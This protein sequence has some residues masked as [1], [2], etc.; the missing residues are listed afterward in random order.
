[1]PLAMA[2]SYDEAISVGFYLHAVKGKPLMERFP[3]RGRC[4]DRRDFISVGLGVRL[5][6]L[7]AR[8]GFNQCGFFAQRLLFIF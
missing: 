2:I 1:M 3:V 5:K 8:V 4:Q 7:L 6:G